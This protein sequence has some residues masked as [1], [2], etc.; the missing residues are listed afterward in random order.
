MKYSYHLYILSTLYLIFTFTT[1]SFS[2]SNAEAKGIYKCVKPNGEVEYTQSR[3][4]M[5]QDHN[6]KKLKNTGG[7][8]DPAAI[9][10]QKAEKENSLK[11]EENRK[12]KELKQQDQELINQEKKHYCDNVQKNLDQIQTS[13]RLF[14]TDDQGNQVILGEEER[15][16]KIQT[17]KENLAIHCS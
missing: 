16:N 4:K 6:T 7:R 12:I 10:K 8:A 17:N 11:T 3:S 15:Q 13:P 1:H 14:K 2:F 5:C 9:A